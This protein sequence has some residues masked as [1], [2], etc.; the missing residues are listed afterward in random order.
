MISLLVFILECAVTAALTGTA[1][2]ALV[3]GLLVIARPLLER[4]TPAKRA[5]LTFMLATAPAALAFAV[6]VAAAMSV[7]ASGNPESGVAT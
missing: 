2:S 6:V 5:D 1:V 3:A 4:M 7:P